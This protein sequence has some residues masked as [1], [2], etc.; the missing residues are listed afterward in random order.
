MI[1]I[2][3][4]SLELAGL[5]TTLSQAEVLKGTLFFLFCPKVKAGGNLPSH[6]SVSLIS[7]CASAPC[8]LLQKM[9]LWYLLSTYVDSLLAWLIT[10][11]RRLLAEVE[12]KRKWSSPVIAQ[13]VSLGWRERLLGLGFSVFSAGPV[14]HLGLKSLSLC[15]L[16]HK[17]PDLCRF[18]GSSVS[19]ES[20]LCSEASWGEQFRGT[21]EGKVKYHSVGVTFNGSPQIVFIRKNMFTGTWSFHSVGTSEPN[22]SFFRGPGSQSA[23]L[24]AKPG[25]ICVC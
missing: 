22:T 19:P 10:S 5:Q 15:C 3:W 8:G 23:L 14:G 21:C 24:T 2:T 13:E 9:R 11:D 20:C 12:I 25:R 18:S 17:Q 16:G 7:N 6:P 1:S 4:D